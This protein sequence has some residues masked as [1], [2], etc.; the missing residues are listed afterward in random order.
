MSHDATDMEQEA[1]PDNG[2]VRS[3]AAMGLPHP[4]HPQSR[5][6]PPPPPQDSPQKPPLDSGDVHSMQSMS[7]LLDRLA[8]ENQDIRL[9]QAELQVGAQHC[10]PQGHHPAPPS[11]LTPRPTSPPGPQGRAAGTAATKR[12]RSSSSWT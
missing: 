9:M 8:K 10:A 1:V 4:Q 11:A 2:S 5:N 3:G 7:V 12:R 6:P